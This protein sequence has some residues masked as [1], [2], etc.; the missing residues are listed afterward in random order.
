MSEVMSSAALLAYASSRAFYCVERIVQ[1]C[2]LRVAPVA[3]THRV[4]QKSRKQKTPHDAGLHREPRGQSM[5]ATFPMMM[6]VHFVAH[7]VMV[8]GERGRHAAQ[9]SRDCNQRQ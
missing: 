1:P 6:H 5:A 7:M 2:F 9:S 4:Q 8:I 3:Y